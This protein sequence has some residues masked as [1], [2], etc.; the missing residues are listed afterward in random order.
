L[1]IDVTGGV[2]N[3]DNIK[4]IC[5]EPATGISEIADDDNAVV[6]NMYNLYGMPVTSGY[7]GI[8]I[9]NGKKL[10]IK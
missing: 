1:R 8:A 9:Q 5:T 2:C 3:I 10:I 6:G 7:R 4:F